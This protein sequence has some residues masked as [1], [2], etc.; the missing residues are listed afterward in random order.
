MTKS[1]EG[2]RKGSNKRLNSEINK[3]RVPT[4]KETTNSPDSPKSAENVEGLKTMTPEEHKETHQHPEPKEV[5]LPL[6]LIFG[7]E[8]KKVKFISEKK[9]LQ[10][11]HNCTMSDSIDD[12]PFL[13]S[14]SPER[15]KQE[16]GI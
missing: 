12:G 15:L 11:M 4:T 6:E 5:K 2:W 14:I 16:L 8:N 9:I 3:N 1:P 13:D 7:F 10:C